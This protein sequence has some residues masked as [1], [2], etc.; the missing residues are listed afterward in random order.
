M[1]KAKLFIINIVILTSTSILMQ[2]ISIFFNAYISKKIG[3]EGIGIFTLIISVYS[4]FITL[5]TSGINLATTRIVSEQFAKGNKEGGLKV[6]TPEF[7]SW[8]I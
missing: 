2:S 8:R 3:T 1:R 7:Y 6:I 5:S 4:F